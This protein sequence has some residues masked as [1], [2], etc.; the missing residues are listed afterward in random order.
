MKKNSCGSQVPHPP[1][2]SPLSNGLSRSD[3]EVDLGAHRIFRTP[4]PLKIYICLVTMAY[5]CVTF[6]RR[7]IQY[8]TPDK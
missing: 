6:A 3:G 5:S 4:H 8:T 2:H 1:P 7:V